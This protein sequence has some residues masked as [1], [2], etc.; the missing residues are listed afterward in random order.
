MFKRAS[1]FILFYQLFAFRI[2]LLPQSALSAAV[3]TYHQVSSAV[4]YC[5]TKRVT[6]NYIICDVWTLCETECVKEEIV[7]K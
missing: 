3:H 5:V 1:F 4:A 7:G 2:S 6:L